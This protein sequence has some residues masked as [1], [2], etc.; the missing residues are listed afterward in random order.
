MFGSSCHS[1]ILLSF[2]GGIGV[3][4][5]NARHFGIELR[6]AFE[7]KIFEAQFDFDEFNRHFDVIATD[8]QATRSVEAFGTQRPR[9]NSILIAFDGIVCVADL[10]FQDLPHNMEYDATF[11]GLGFLCR[12]FFECLNEVSPISHFWIRLIQANDRL[13]ATRLLEQ[14]R[15]RAKRFSIVWI[16]LQCFLA[17]FNL[18]FHGFP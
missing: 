12:V 7:W 9:F 14:L 16:P 13:P 6:F 8:I 17:C 1:R 5:A 11:L 3:F 10:E 4:S 2:I 15:K 18:L